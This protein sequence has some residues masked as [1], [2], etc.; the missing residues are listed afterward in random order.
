MNPIENLKRRYK[1]GEIA[2]PQFIEE[3]HKHHRLL[4][5]FAS[6]LKE[7]DV[8]RIEIT[9]DGV[10]Y[11]SRRYGVKI[12]TD[13]ED[14]RPA[15][16][17]AF[18]FGTYEQ[19]ETDVMLALLKPGMTVYDVG[20]NLGWY[21]V[22]FSKSVENLKIHAFE[23]VPITRKSLLKNLELNG[24]RNVTVHPH[25][26]S[27]QSGEISFFYYPEGSVNASSARLTERANQKELKLPVKTLD[28]T[29]EDLK[30]PPQ[31]IKCDVEGA[32]FM[33]FQGGEKTL[34]EHK[35]IVF[36]EMLRKWAEPFGYHPN[37]MI[38]F[39]SKLGYKCQ[40]ITNQGLKEFSRMDE[41][42]VETNFVFTP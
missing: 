9:D 8:A 42:T 26:L 28:E 22:I 25:G 7:T 15:P 27:N 34:R 17:D 41:N 11:T 24:V 13:I 32:E 31:F 14:Q 30:A 10:I 1:A 36:A 12:K 19:A 4:H 29:V 33:V 35:P 40:A 2:K 3:M 21:S 37:E 39:F 38:G 20:A 5:D 6:G 18:N 16:L 23:P